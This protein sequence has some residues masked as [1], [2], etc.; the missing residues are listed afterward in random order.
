[1]NN[2]NRT[3]ILYHGN[4]PDGFGGAF[5]AWKKFGD[6]AEYRPLSYG[7]PVPE[8]LAGAYVYFIDFCYP[9]D[10]MNRLAK[11]AA[12]F[13]VLD[14]HLG[15]K[16]VVTSMPEYV[17]DENRSGATI[18]WSYF[19]PDTPVPTLLSYVEDGDLYR[20]QL[21]DARALLTYLYAEPFS[22]ERWNTL[23][24]E[25]EDP[26]TRAVM[27]ER[28]TLYRTYYEHLLQQFAD[29]AERVSFEGYECLLAPSVGIFTSDLGNRLAR[30]VPPLALLIHARADGL[31]VSLRGDG[32]VDVAAI[33]RMYGGYGHPNAA[34]FPLPWGAPIPWTKLDES[35][36]D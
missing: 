9:K 29:R 25:L 20:H 19:H 36:G 14:H 22:F 32:S 28:G 30:E 12:S 5:A 33:A 18:A 7:K 2:M 4:C 17:F 31:R 6:T 8:D 27:V 16:E 24:Q 13:M 1:M 34:A 35:A 26:A 3:L 10:V 11:D 21:P 15:V 23:M